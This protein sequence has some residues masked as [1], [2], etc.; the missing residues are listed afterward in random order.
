M[1]FR[2][3]RRF[4]SRIV[5]SDIRVDQGVVATDVAESLPDK[6]KFGLPLDE[7]LKAGAISKVIR[8]Q[9]SN[10]PHQVRHVMQES[11]S[12]SA[13]SRLVSEEPSNTLAEK[14]KGLLALVG[15]GPADLQ[16]HRREYCSELALVPH[17]KGTKSAYHWPRVLI[18]R[19][20]AARCPG[21]LRVDPVDADRSILLLDQFLDKTSVVFCFSGYDLSG[22]NTGVKA[23]KKVL[24]ETS[25]QVLHVH[26][27]DGWL[28]R[29]THP[30]TRQILRSFRSEEIEPSRRDNL[31][32]Y[33]G[34]LTR[35]I[36]LDFHAYNKA[37]PSIL[38]VD[39]A[40]Y[41]RWHAV[42]LPT[43]ESAALG[44]SLLNKLVREKV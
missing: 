9:W 11:Q 27:C 14:A 18:P 10:I 39:K 42:G 25:A 29:R 37:L 4:C 22:L 17:P 1:K 32:I 16:L 26:I 3:V 20:V 43:D 12:T 23:W 41:I 35:E 13:I 31:F 30:L 38:L 19:S 33:R 21:N 44:A 24:P 7:D 5:P 34:K 2:A 15:K 36:A 8:N 28:S 6:L 40:G